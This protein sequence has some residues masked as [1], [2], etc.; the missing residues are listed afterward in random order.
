VA[1]RLVQAP[2]KDAAA[3]GGDQ[4]GAA[5]ADKAVEEGVAEEYGRPEFKVLYRFNEGYT[6]A[7]KRPLLLR[8]LV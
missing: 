8:D 2:K 4:A 3:D 7:V 6:N 5:V 1:H